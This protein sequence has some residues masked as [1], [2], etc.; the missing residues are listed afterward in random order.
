MVN[1]D[2]LQGRLFATRVV[3]IQSS[4][5]R[6]LQ[7]LSIA[8]LTLSIVFWKAISEDVFSWFCSSE[9][10]EGEIAIQVRF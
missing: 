1:W 6:T 8:M 3:L 4:G 5:G 10:Y 7:F 2:Y 9:G